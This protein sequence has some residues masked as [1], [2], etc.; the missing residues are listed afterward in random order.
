MKAVITVKVTRRLVEPIMEVGK[1]ESHS[2]EKC[3]GRVC[4][5]D[6]RD[7]VET[8]YGRSSVLEE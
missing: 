1:G 8:E 7:A 3:I 5:T 2:L 4:D 6:K